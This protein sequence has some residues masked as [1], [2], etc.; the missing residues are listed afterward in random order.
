MNFNTVLNNFFKNS[1]AGGGGGGI[2][3]EVSVSKNSTNMFKLWVHRNIQG[4]RREVYT[5]K[6]KTL[7]TLTKSIL[8]WSLEK[9]KKSLFI[10]VIKKVWKR[11]I[12]GWDQ[13][14]G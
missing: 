3:R 1:G 5:L 6:L 9:K 12:L 4:E 10:T 7:L 2:L 8:Q 13:T 11:S 14:R